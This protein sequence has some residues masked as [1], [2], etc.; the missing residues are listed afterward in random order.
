M[1][2]LSR[3]EG[4]TDDWILSGKYEILVEGRKY[5]AKVHLKSP[6]DAN[7]ARPKM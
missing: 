2:Y 5:T 6:Y 3:A 4:I 7:N 1:G